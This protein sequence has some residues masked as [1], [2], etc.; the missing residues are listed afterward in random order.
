MAGDM[1]DADSHRQ[2]SAAPNNDKQ[3][4]GLK[5]RRYFSSRHRRLQH[6]SISPRLTT[7]SSGFAP[8]FPRST[9]HYHL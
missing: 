6:D 3:R 9:A 7:M 1:H 4:A 2:A 8:I 5:P